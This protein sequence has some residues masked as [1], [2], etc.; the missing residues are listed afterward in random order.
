MRV[1]W[2]VTAARAI[3]LANRSNPYRFHLLVIGV[4]S[5]PLVAKAGPKLLRPRFTRSSE[6]PA[7]RWRLATFPQFR[8]QIRQIHV[9]HRQQNEQ[10]I[11]DIGTLVGNF[12][13]VVVF[14]RE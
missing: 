7:P 14:G 11:D 3:P 13:P 12:F 1:I 5:D 4:A 2:G 10:V 8:P 9:F 6:T